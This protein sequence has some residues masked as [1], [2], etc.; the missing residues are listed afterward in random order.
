MPADSLAALA[1]V[2]MPAGLSAS[3]LV[4]SVAALLER[5]KRGGAAPPAPFRAETESYYFEGRCLLDADGAAISFLDRAASDGDDWERF[6]AAYGQNYPEL[7]AARNAPGSLGDAELI[8]EIGSSVLRV[9]Q[10]DSVTRL[11]FVAGGS[12]E[13]LLCRTGDVVSNARRDSDSLR[14]IVNG[15]PFPVWFISDHGSLVWVNAAYIETAELANTRCDDGHWPP[16]VLFE[17]ELLRQTVESGPRR[18]P[19]RA[20]PPETQRWYEVHATPISGGTVF[21]AIRIDDAVRAENKLR[22]FTQTLSTTFAHLTVG[23]AIFDRSR[24]LVLFNPAL[25]ELTQLPADFLTS[26]PS[27]FGFLD[28][29]REMRVIP[30]PKDYAAWRQQMADLEAA[31]VDGS[32]AQTWSLSTGQTYRVTGRPHPDGAII[33]LFEDISAEISLTRRFRTEL[34]LGQA[35]IDSL[36]EAIAVFTA[37]GTLATSNEAYASLWGNDPGIELTDITVLEATATWLSKTAPTPA[38][39]DFRDF[40]LRGHDRAEWTAEVRMRDGRGLFCKF[41]PI[42]SGG[43]MA[44]FRP[45][46]AGDAVAAGAARERA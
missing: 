37:S 29:M 40:V 17:E 35:V 4:V 30:E 43:T 31:A 3:V 33:F 12:A 32:Y 16:D 8:A 26:R 28:R 6:L 44:S 39:G 24:R 1:L 25:T 11:Q 7:A 14:T 18:M 21:A 13:A 46:R 22:E 23:L 10:H 27:M 9:T 42:R 15:V 2:A 45:V 19:L 20:L 34:E 41:T 38:W 5:F 36:P